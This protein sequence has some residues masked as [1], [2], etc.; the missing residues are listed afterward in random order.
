MLFSRAGFVEFGRSVPAAVAQKS[1]CDVLDVLVSGVLAAPGRTPEEPSMHIP[2]ARPFAT[3]ATIWSRICF[4]ATDK[5]VGA[6]LLTCVKRAVVTSRLTEPLHQ[7]SVRS[8]VGA[9]A[10]N[11]DFFCCIACLKS[12]HHAIVTC[13]G[14]DKQHFGML[15]VALQMYNLFSVVML[16]IRSMFIAFFKAVGVTPSH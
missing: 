4:K 11:S 16:L 5:L 10:P 14:E 13:S 7:N 8:F 3:S 12:A 2:C 6:S 9:L 15:N 1:L